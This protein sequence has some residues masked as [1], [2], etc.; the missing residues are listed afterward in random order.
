MGGEKDLKAE[1]LRRKSAE[2]G[3]SCKPTISGGGPSVKE[4]NKERKTSP[5]PRLWC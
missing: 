2:D 3:G 1:K 4:E 5:L